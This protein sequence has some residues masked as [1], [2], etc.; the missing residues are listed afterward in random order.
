MT[1]QHTLV[2][3]GPSLLLL[4]FLSYLSWM[5]QEFFETHL[6]FFS[7]LFFFASVLRSRVWLVGIRSNA[8][9]S[10][11]GCWMATRQVGNKDSS[12]RNST[13]DKEEDKAEECRRIVAQIARQK[14]ASS[15]IRAVETTKKNPPTSYSSYI[16]FL[17]S[18]HPSILHTCVRACVH[19]ASLINLRPCFCVHFFVTAYRTDRTS[20]PPS[21][22]SSLSCPGPDNPRF[23]DRLVLV[24]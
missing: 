19:C 15:R 17:P 5:R 20:P 7:S 4:Y 14:E 6:T 8:V 1:R 11:S 16:P 10:L 2:K 9:M 18:P 12:G 3:G 13:S 23:P 22:P 21:L 24:S